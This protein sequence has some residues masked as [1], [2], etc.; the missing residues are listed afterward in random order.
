MSIEILGDCADLYVPCS[1]VFEFCRWGGSWRAS[2]HVVLQI[3]QRNTI[4]S[5]NFVNGIFK[6]YKKPCVVG[7]AWCVACCAPQCTII[8]S[9]GSHAIL[10]Q[11]QYSNSLA[12]GMARVILALAASGTPAPAGKRWK[13]KTTV[14]IDGRTVIKLWRKALYLLELTPDEAYLDSRHP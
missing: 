1:T 13:A 8:V 2:E 14:P 10:D 7:L 4:L 3:C 5:A 9:V 12:N 11:L 6:S